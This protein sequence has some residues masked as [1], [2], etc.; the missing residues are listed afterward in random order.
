MLLAGKP[1][2]EIRH[3]LGLSTGQYTYMYGHRDFKEMLEVLRERI[4]SEFIDTIAESDSSALNSRPDEAIELRE[5]LAGIRD[6]ALSVI[7][8]GLIED[9]PGLRYS[10]AF[11]ALNL[12]LG[13]KINLPADVKLNEDQ[14]S[15]LSEALDMLKGL[16]PR[17]EH[18][19]QKQ[20]EE[21]KEQDA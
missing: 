9:K 20:L 6:E 17:V 2:R 14:Q 5:R 7:E 1:R 11:K 21:P 13:E 10:T 4:D 19:E 18:L 12:T 3:V 16:T 8:E 15:A